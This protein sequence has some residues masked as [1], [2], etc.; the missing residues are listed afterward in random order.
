MHDIFTLLKPRWLSI[1]NGWTRARKGRLPLR[2]LL[3]VALG[4]LFWWGLYTGTLRALRYFRTIEDIGDILNLKLL[5][6]IHLTA[7]ALLIFSGILTA[8]AKLYLSRDLYLVHA[9]PVSRHKIFIA[10]WIDASVDSSWMV[11]TFVLPVFIAYG[12][13]YRA[14]IAY[15]IGIPLQLLPLALTAS[16]FGA[17]AVLTAVMLV[18][19]SRMKN[20]FIFLSLLFFVGLYLAVRLLKPEQLVDPDVFDSLMVYLTALQTPSAPWLPSTWAFDGIRTALAGDLGPSL[21]NAGLSWSCA[22]T[23]FCCTAVLADAVYFRGFSR[24]QTA[25]KRPVKS[26]RLVE[27]AADRLPGPV[28]AYIVK[29][30]R[31]FF[32][33]QS[34]WSQLF[35][36]AALVFIYLY[37]FKALPIEKSPI[38]TVY[39]QNLLAFLNMGLALFVLT[40]VAGRF[41][42][43]AVS[44][45]KEA[46]WLVRAYP[47]SLRRFLWIKFSIYYLPLLVL[48]EFL[49]VATNLLLE[50]APAMMALSVATVFCVVPAITALA[51][52]IG[53][54]YPDFRAENPTQSVT[55]FGGLMFMVLSTGIIAAVIALEAGPVYHL[56]VAAFHGRAPTTLETLWAAGTFTAVPVLSLAALWTAMRF[57]EQRLAAYEF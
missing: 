19:A 44:S 29:E 13:A 57:G 26:G 54:A 1:R 10:R 32:R 9:L 48:T 28:R 27:A 36:I 46:F 33:D 38:Q 30:L 34:Q 51:V 3:P 42:Y 25:Q 14:G 21:F 52:G 45:E 53:A 47:G 39:L 49:I 35:L 41:A 31:S 20:V 2:P 11:L 6:M 40:A 8:L 56:L 50:V 17:A 24:T 5:S 12:V 16:S 43:P 15:Y 7:F 55:S 23:L 22:A 18:P 4:A 37:N